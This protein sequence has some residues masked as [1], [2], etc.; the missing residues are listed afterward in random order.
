MNTT[1][2]VALPLVALSA[3]L[4]QAAESTPK[5][6]NVIF[7]MIEDTSPQYMAIYNKGKGAPTPNL[8]KILKESI[9]YDNAFSNAP[10]S[11]A[12]RTTLITGCYAPRFGG[13]LHRKLEELQMPEGLRMFP[14]YLREAGYYTINASK[15]DYNVVLDE[16]AWNQIKG[17]LSDW[18]K[19]KEKDQP[20]FMQ[21]TNAVTHESKL[22]FNEETYKTVKTKTNLKDV[23]VHPN[24]PNTDLMKYTYATFYDRIMDADAEFGKMLGLLKEDGLMDDT[25]IFFFG[26]NGGCVPESKGY[27][28]DVGFRVPLVVYVPEKWRKQ[29]DVPV[30]K[31]C[32]GIVSFKDFGVT[33]LHL[34]GIEIPEQCDGVPFLGKDTANGSESVVCYGDRFDDLYAFNRALYRGDFRYARNYTPYHIQG[35]HS[36]YRYK[37][38]ALQE[39]RELFYD[40]KLNADQARFFEPMGAE[41]LYNLKTDPNELNNLANDPQYQAVVKQMRVEL[42][43]QLDEYCDLGFLPETIITEQ[44]M[45]NPATWGEEHRAE[46]MTYRRLADL[47]CQPFSDKVRRELLRAMKSDDDVARWWG[48]TTTAWFEKESPKCKC[49]VGATEALAASYERSFVRSRAYV[50][51]AKLG[52]NAITEDIAIDMLRKSRTLGETLLVLNDLAYLHDSGV[53]PTFKKMKVEDAPFTNYSVNERVAFLTKDCD[54]R[55]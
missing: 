34:A 17:G 5:K 8:S 39:A 42:A 13:S 47:Q 21:R 50:A 28:N 24:L 44:A 36:Y 37:S 40:G 4:V 3:N 41:E 11:S 20:F 32:D 1:K 9:V 35:M 49:L 7:Y 27:T 46:L 19:R 14:S 18:R 22:L 52:K 51:L 38:L 15:T 30:G 29:I 2:L 12:A 45:K 53:M 55:N 26:D 6:P 54:Y 43:A 23:Y 25:F 10:V 16:T 33:A 48:M 31:H